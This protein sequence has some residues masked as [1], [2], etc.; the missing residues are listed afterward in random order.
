[1]L[2]FLAHPILE[3]WLHRLAS[4]PIRN[5]HVLAGSDASPFW[6]LVGVG[7]RLVLHVMVHTE[8][9]N[10]SARVGPYEPL[11]PTR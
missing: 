11:R 9:A 1:M 8:R 5:V 4:T 2:P 6:T 3:G 10:R 7:R